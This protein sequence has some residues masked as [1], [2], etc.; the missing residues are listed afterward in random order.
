[1]AAARGAL[2]SADPTIY[3]V[4]ERVG[5]DM[6]QRRIVELLRPL[7][8]R[9]LTHR[10]VRALVGADQFI[11]YQQYNPHARVAPDVYVL[12]GVAPDAAV[13]SWKV[14][15]TG[16]V[17]SFALEV[18]SR[19]WE[20]DYAEAPERYAALGVE[21]LV[22]FDPQYTARRDGIRFQRFRRPAHAGLQL[23]ERTDA[24]RVASEVLGCIIRAVGVDQALRLRLALPPDGTE[25]FPTAEE[26]ALER[27]SELEAELRR[28]R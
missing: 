17:P 22:L 18:V 7:I 11:Y 25:L 9:W 27:I 10:G 2:A 14:W 13:P 8:E 15:E 21:E 5:E 19:D 23:A 6:L 4:E 12:P 3:P 24:D 16:I 26:A 20:K 28:R 1:M